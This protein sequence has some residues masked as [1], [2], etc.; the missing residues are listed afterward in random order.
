MGLNA[1]SAQG[2]LRLSRL[3]DTSHRLETTLIRLGGNFEDLE[4]HLLRN[5]RKYAHRDVVER[6]SL[7]H[8]FSLTHLHGLPT[9][10]MDWT[11][12]PYAALHFAYSD[13]ASFEQEAAIWAVNFRKAHEFLPNFLK[14]KLDQGDAFTVE[15][16]SRLE[17]RGSVEEA[18]PFSISVSPGKTIDTLGDFDA[19]SG[20]VDQ[21]FL[22]F[23]E[24]PSIDDRIVN[25]FALFSVMSDP[26]AP[27]DEWLE[28][29]PD[30]FHKIIIPANPKLK[31][32]IR[33]KL[34]TKRTLRRG[35]CSRTSTV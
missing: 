32:G 19:L 4:R 12:S 7:W 22:L 30:L 21:D 8:W 33:D 3:S 14:S 9:R 5:F 24:P 15:M 35:A 11:Y 28:G 18:E 23:L 29:H 20:E 16:L 1:R 13:V 10:L 27:I 31:W 34:S 25:Q 6:D 26:T 17:T 2:A